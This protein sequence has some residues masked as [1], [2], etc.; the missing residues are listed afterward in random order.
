MV[1]GIRGGLTIA[2]AGNF[3][4]QHDVGS[5]RKRWSFTNCRSMSLKRFRSGVVRRFMNETKAHPCQGSRA[6]HELQAPPPKEAY[7]HSLNFSCCIL[8]GKCRKGLRGKSI[9]NL[10]RTTLHLISSATN[11]VPRNHT[12]HVRHTLTWRKKH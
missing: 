5:C 3:T 9:K 10:D 12:F 6:T 2:W 7:H 11:M 4:R 8:R 1:V